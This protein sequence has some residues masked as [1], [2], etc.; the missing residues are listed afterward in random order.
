[1]TTRNP[2]SIAVISRAFPDAITALSVGRGIWERRALLD[3]LPLGRLRECGAQWVAVNHRLAR[4]GVLRQCATAGFPAMV[5]TVNDEPLMRRFLTD[6]RVAV[7][8]TDRPRA[9]V[10]LRDDQ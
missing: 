7:L 8:V 5:W 3:L 2:A 9:A 6:P 1:V 10:R 4:L